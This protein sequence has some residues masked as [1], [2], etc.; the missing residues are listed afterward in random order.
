MSAAELSDLHTRIETLTT[1]ERESLRA[2]LHL[3]KLRDDPAWKARISESLNGP[4][5]SEAE[6]LALHQ[7]LCTE[8]R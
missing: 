7:R 2:Y 4:F 3:L 6:V 1:E 5:H 8:G